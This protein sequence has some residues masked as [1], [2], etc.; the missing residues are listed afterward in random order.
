MSSRS[1]TDGP[2][3]TD[4]APVR[5]RASDVERLAVAEV[6]QDAVGKGLLTLTEGDERTAAALAAV[7]RDELTPL[8][9]DL[10][11]AV[12]PRRHRGPGGARPHVKGAAGSGAG[13]WQRLQAQVGAWWLLIVATV[14][15]WSPRRRIVVGV[16]VA[17]LVL[18]LVGFGGFDHDGGQR[19]GPAGRTRG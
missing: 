15:G 10:P 12:H 18:M 1:H 6:L 3:V 4:G 9:A 17:V 2:T 8:T 13:R 19:G 14:G 5:L 16:A 11:P 7:Y